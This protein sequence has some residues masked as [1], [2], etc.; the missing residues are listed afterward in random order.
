MLQLIYG[1][2]FG[3][4]ALLGMG[5]AKSLSALLQ[6]NYYLKRTSESSRLFLQE[7]FLDLYDISSPRKRWIYVVSPIL[8]GLMGLVLSNGWWGAGLAGMGVGLVLPRPLLKQ[9][10]AVRRSKFQSQLV[11]ML[12][13]VCSSLRAGMSMLQSFTVVA[14]EMPPPISEEFELLVKETSMGVSVDEAMAHFRARM[15][16]DETSLFVTGVLVARETGGDVTTVFTKL[17][18]TLRE[19]K[20][21]IERIKTLTFMARLQGVVMVILPIVFS[22]STYSIDPGHFS[23]FMN[24]P[25]G[26]MMLAG[27]VGVQ[28]LS[29]FLF[30]RF[31]RSPL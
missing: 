19:R 29:M 11:D 27:V 16:S 30:V 7:T 25:Q 1:V 12:L 20:K 26:R 14:E 5:L 28:A 3:S 10:I 17:I 24:D 13:L 15:P 21:I 22:Y 23:F 2:T 31:S 18:D 6:I 8:C 9:L 4:G